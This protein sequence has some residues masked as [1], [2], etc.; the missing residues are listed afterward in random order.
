MRKLKILARLVFWVLISILLLTRSNMLPSDR[1][2]QVRAFTRHIEFDYVSWTLD[3]LG[4]KAMQAALGA[5]QYMPPAS[6]K[7]IIRDYLIVLNDVLRTEARLTELY[8]DPNADK[9]GALAISYRQQLENLQDYYDHIAPLAESILQEQISSVLADLNLTFI[10]QPVPPV[11]YHTSPL[12]LDLIVSPRN[13]IRQEADVSLLPDMTVAEKDAL[14]N[15][16]D[17]ALN[18]SSLVVPVGGIGIYP[19]MVMRST[20]LDWV[21]EVISHEWTHNFLTLRP[22]GMSYYNS[23]QLR[24]MNETTAN[25][26][27]KEIGLEVV[28]RYY[29]ELAPAPAPDTKPAAPATSQPAQAA[30][31]EPPVFDFQVEMH[32]T[33]VRVDELLAEGKIE[34]AENYME[35]RRQFLWEHGYHLR[36]LNQAYFAFYG[37]Y[38]DTPA[39]SGSA[40][41]DPVGPAVLALRQ[42]SASLADFLNRISWMSSFEQLQSAVQ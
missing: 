4:L 35:E 37:A 9:E 13:V 5:E 12:P 41:K 19:T 33:R 27:G 32:E 11:L 18:V 6:Q 2:E 25:I 29:P 7:K 16:I 42:N 17:R 39:G 20:D 3:A 34:E 14:E 26:A 36:K 24:T 38:A 8:S 15:Q 31:D 10:G 1:F 30:P 28:K 21:I 22:L 40:G 23:A